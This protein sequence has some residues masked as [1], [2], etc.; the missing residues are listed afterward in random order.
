MLFHFWLHRLVR[1]RASLASVCISN[2]TRRLLRKNS[3]E[4][5][6]PPRCNCVGAF[7]NGPQQG[8][9]EPPSAQRRVMP[10]I[11]RVDAPQLRRDLVRASQLRCIIDERSM[12]ART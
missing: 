1:V 11:C 7:A 3:T 9:F 5:S 12:G 10:W 4:S 2:F 6:L 8:R